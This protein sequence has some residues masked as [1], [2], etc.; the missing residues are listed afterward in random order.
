MASKNKKESKIK[1]KEKNKNKMTPKNYRIL[2]RA[3]FDAENSAKSFDN[4]DD[5]I[6]DIL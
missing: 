3:I 1:I 5:L 4:V 6:K 2:Q